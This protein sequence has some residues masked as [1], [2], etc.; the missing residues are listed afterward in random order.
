MDGP[1]LQDYV[2]GAFD[3]GHPIAVNVIDFSTDPDRSTWEAV[4]QA[5]GGGYQNLASSDS[6][7]LTKALTT[8]VG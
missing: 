3:P 7:D 4:A 1:A 8:F 2:R 6:P 5:S